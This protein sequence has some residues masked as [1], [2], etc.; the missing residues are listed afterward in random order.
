MKLPGSLSCLFA[1]LVA[2]ATAN[3]EKTIF[4]APEAVAFTDSAPT[5]DVL[6]LQVLTHDKSTLR[7]ALNVVFPTEETPQGTDHWFL[8]RDLNPHQRYELRV[9][10]AAIQPTEFWLDT[11][12]I[13]E[14]FDTPNL[15]QNLA[16]YAEN[17]ERPRPDPATSSSP[18]KESVL[19]LHL[20][21]TADFFTTNKQLMSSPPLVDVDLILDPFVFNVFPRSLGPTAAYIVVL[22]VGA[23][24]VSGYVW[25]FLKGIATEKSHRE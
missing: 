12:T 13:S 9:C 6:Q 3:T 15:I 18:E 22:A 25:R 23:W 4:T 5:L 10:W 24:L 8:L 14:V 21:A 17:S 20:R 2:S 11:Y 1:L 16:A 19:F 7:T